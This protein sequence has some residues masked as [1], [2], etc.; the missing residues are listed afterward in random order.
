MFP[1]AVPPQGPLG[2]FPSPLRGP[3][4]CWASIGTPQSALWMSRGHTT[5]TGRCRDAASLAEPAFGHNR[6]VGVAEERC[7]PGRGSGIRRRKSDSGGF[8]SQKRFSK[9][10]LGVLLVDS[11]QPYAIDKNLWMWCDRATSITHF[12][13]SLLM[14]STPRDRAEAM[15]TSPMGPGED[16]RREHYIN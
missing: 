5:S 16:S 6:L 8:F 3:W 12:V 15:G 11:Q 10:C 14:P 1:P 13:G 7:A 4:E 2:T 9:T